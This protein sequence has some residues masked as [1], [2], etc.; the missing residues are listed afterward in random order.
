MIIHDTALFYTGNYTFQVQLLDQYD[1]PPKPQV[2]LRWIYS[3]IENNSYAL[4]NAVQQIS[5]F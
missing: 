1:M 2:F 4:Q 5:W 3:G